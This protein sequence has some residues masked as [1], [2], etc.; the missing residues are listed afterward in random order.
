MRAAL[1]LLALI[2]SAPFAMAQLPVPTPQACGPLELVG[3]PTAPADPVA[4]D[5][6]VDVALAV[7][8]AGSIAA[9]VDAGASISQGGWTVDAPDAQTVPAGQDA[10]FRFT[11]TRTAD[12]SEDAVV[13]LQANGAC[14]P[15]GGTCAPSTPAGDPCNAGVVNPQVTLTRAPDQGF[16]VPGLDALGDVRAEYL[17]AAVVLIG[18]AS[19]IPF[20][21]RR[22]KGS[23]IADCPEPLKMVKPG[24]GT[25][26]PIEIRNGGKDATS[27]TFEIGAVPEGWSAFMPLP[28][29]QLAARESRSLWLMVRSPATAAIG[30]VVDVELRLRDVKGGANG[31]VVRVRA[32]VAAGAE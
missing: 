3:E 25:S 24:R 26:F 18:L 27:A 12:A 9:R 20:A 8:N 22:K 29:V 21:M 6:E 32:E 4:V 23:L 10:T 30:D 28:E 5:E 1:L 15:P 31:A 16:R 19:A 17:I 2:G 11:I 13:L 14:T 7:R